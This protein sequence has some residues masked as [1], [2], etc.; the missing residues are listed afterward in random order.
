VIAPDEGAALEA[1]S[2]YF[3]AADERRAVRVVV[4]G[5]DLGYLE[6]GQALAL[7]DVQSREVGHSSGWTLP[8]V[9]D[10]EGIE[11]CCPVEGC[12]ANPIFTGTFDERY[13]LD[14]PLHPGQAL[15]LARA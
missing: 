4:G 5:E 2:A 14:C 12:Q 10:Y 8:G 11:L 15:I 6:R 13:P 3:G 1:L 9:S 7:L